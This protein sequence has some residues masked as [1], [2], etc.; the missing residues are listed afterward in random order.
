MA[1][2]LDDSAERNLQPSH[3]PPA[4][5]APLP[6]Q[7]AGRPMPEQ[8]AVDRVNFEDVVGKPMWSHIEDEFK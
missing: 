4:K 6:R 5:Q 1:P 3:A 7:H 2:L 8:E